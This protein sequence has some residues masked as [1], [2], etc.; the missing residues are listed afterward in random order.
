MHYT[1][2]RIS[3]DGAL[4]EC[5]RLN[6]FA[7]LEEW[8]SAALGRFA[9]IQVRNDVTGEVRAFTDCGTHFVRVS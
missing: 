5:A 7:E 2:H 6:N 8:V 3:L 4:T 1:A 9:N